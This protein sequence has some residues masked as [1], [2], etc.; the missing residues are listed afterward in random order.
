MVMRI[1]SWIELSFWQLAVRVLSGIRPLSH[2]MSQAKTML[3]AQPLTRFLPQGWV[4]ALSGWMLG[5]VLGIALATW[6]L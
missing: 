4:L 5:L 1:G 6:V 3:E 2:S